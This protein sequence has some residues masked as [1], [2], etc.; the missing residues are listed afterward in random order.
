MK[1]QAILC[2][3]PL[4]ARIIYGLSKHCLAELSLGGI[5]NLCVS[6]SQRNSVYI[7]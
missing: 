2:G 7:A 4:P 3:L 6:T 1:F 5:M